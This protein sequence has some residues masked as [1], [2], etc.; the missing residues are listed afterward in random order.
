MPMMLDSRIFELLRCI[1]A[2]DRL[3]YVVTKVWRSVTV[4]FCEADMSSSAGTTVIDSYWT[5]RWSRAYRAG[6]TAWLS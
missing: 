5:K 4:M 2:H 1:R 6:T 3:Q